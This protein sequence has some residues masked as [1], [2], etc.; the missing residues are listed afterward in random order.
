VT[1]ASAGIGR[2]TAI[3]L[4]RRGWSVIG[5]GRDLARISAAEAE[6]RA[7][8]APEAKVGFVRADFTRMADVRRAA[9]EIR[10]LATRIEVLINNAGGV[11]DRLVVTPDGTEATFAANHLA[12]F[13]LTREL[14]PV[15][16]ATARS[17]PA[18]TVRV[19]AVSSS[20]H[21][22][23]PG[24]HWEDLNLLDNF[25]TAAA[26]CQAKLANLLFTRELNRR[27]AADGIVAQ[28][29]HPGVVDSNFMAH[30][31]EVMRAFMKTQ[32]PQT[33]EHAARTLVFLATSPEAGR[34]GGRYFHD[35]REVAPAPQALDDAAARRLWVASEELLTKLGY[36]GAVVEAPRVR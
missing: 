26:Y 22:F 33:P 29:M 23:C 5:V 15:L 32:T 17:R 18:G 36:P 20:G 8:A 28:C 30:A 25:S 14:H 10:T 4:A 35:E 9:G 21:A 3:A 31:D 6:I 12:P 1:G 7:A 24:M 2:A 11:R 34:D 16:E 27:A 19:V 13:L